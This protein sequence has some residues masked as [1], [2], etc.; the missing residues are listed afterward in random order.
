VND[1]VARKMARVLREKQEDAR[2]HRNELAE[3]LGIEVTDSA[4]N[5][6]D[7]LD[8]VEA[9]MEGPASGEA[10]TMEE[11][12]DDSDDG[13]K[14]PLSGQLLGTR[15]SLDHLQRSRRGAR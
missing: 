15:T 2:K 12:D 9:G 14:E 6:P 8:D 4:Y 13:S 3:Q 5:E 7:E 10:T 11:S 1:A